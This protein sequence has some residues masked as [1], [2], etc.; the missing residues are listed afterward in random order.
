MHLL[1]L[2]V[3]PAWVG[4]RDLLGCRVGVPIVRVALGLGLFYQF[5]ALLAPDRLEYSQ[6]PITQGWWKIQDHRA[7]AQNIMEGCNIVQ[8]R[9]FPMRLGNIA[10]VIRAAGE[11]RGITDPALRREFGNFWVVRLGRDLSCWVRGAVIFA[12]LGIAAG[13]ATCLYRSLRRK[14][15]DK[16]QMGSGL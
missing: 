14:Q 4:M 5:C 2:F 3:Y 10:S 7:R 16:K 12:W 9:Q 1:P 11:G 6:V 13:A 8:Q 15:D